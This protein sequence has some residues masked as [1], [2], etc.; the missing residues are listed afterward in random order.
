MEKSSEEVLRDWPRDKLEE[1]TT[2]GLKTFPPTFDVIFG[3]IIKS[4]F[5]Y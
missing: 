5:Y 2:A 1:E 4:I 3:S